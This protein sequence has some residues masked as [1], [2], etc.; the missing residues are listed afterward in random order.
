MVRP[1]KL[2]K[3]NPAVESPS[4]FPSRTEFLARLLKYL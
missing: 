3:G 4:I 2:F 1:T